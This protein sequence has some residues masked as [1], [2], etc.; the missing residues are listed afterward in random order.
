MDWQP[1]STAPFDRELE[2][3][4][5]DHEGTHTLVF[6]CRRILCGWLKAGTAQRIE[7]YPTHGVSGAV[8]TFGGE[9]E[10]ADRGMS[11]ALVG[12]Q[13]PVADASVINL[14]CYHA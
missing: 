6:P 13:S 7:V 10:T 5:M 1:I 11:A 2:L 14:S 9:H 3:A 8:S 12:F 4:V